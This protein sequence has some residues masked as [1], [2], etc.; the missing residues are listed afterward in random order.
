MEFGAVWWLTA[1]AGVLA[2]WAIASELSA[3][4][5]KLK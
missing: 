2:L 4:G 3:I 5:K 1:V